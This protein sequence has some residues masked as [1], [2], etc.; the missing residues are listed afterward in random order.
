MGRGLLCWNDGIW[1]LLSKGVTI[2]NGNKETIVDT[3]LNR[4]CQPLREDH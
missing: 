3:I 1:F 2:E 4:K